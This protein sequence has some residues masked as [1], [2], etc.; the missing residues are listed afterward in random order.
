MC[1]DQ[2]EDPNAPLP[3]I[4][5]QIQQKEAAKVLARTAPI[6]QCTMMF[7]S[8]LIIRSSL[9]LLYFCTLSLLSSNDLVTTRS[10]GSNPF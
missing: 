7:W 5:E 1:V 4:A 3:S 8:V 2:V 6:L 10:G 9:V